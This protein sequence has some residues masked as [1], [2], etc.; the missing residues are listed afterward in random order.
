MKFYLNGKKIRRPDT[1]QQ[2]QINLAYEF[3]YFVAGCTGGNVG[4][5]RGAL[6]RKNTSPDQKK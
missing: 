4:A 2:E 5:T 1:A 6:I 3:L